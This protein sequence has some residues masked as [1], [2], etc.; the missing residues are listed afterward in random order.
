MDWW[1]G[2]ISRWTSIE[3]TG[4]GRWL[5][6]V[7]WLLVFL[8]WVFS[9]VFGSARARGLR[10]AAWAAS[11]SRAE[12]HT[13]YTSHVHFFCRSHLTSRLLAISSTSPPHTPAL[14]PAPAFHFYPRRESDLL[15]CRL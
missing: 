8:H 5:V 7:G 11:G 1:L 15:L 6:L 2:T 14:A 10:L 4:R 3:R 12:T 13:V 9:I